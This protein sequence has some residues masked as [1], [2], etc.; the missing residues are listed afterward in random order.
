MKAQRPPVRDHLPGQ[1]LPARHHRR[2]A[3]A[4]VPPG[5]GARGGPRTSRW[6]TS[7]R[8]LELFAREMFGPRVA[9]A[10]PAVV[11]PVHRAVG[12]GRTCCCFKCGGDGC[13]FCKQSGW[14]EIL[15][16][17]MVHP[18]VLRNVGYDPE[19]VTG[20][21]FGMGV[22]RVAMLKYE[23]DDIRL[24]FEND[25]RFLAAVRR[26]APGD[27]DLVPLAPGVRRDGP[28][29]PRESPTASSMRASRWRR[30]PRSSRGS[31]GV[32]VGEIEAIERGA[33]RDRAPGHQQPPLRV[34]LP[35]RT[36]LRGLRRAQRARRACARRSRPPGATLPGGREIEAAKIRG[37]VSEGMLCSEKELGLGAG[38]RRHPR[39]CPPTRR[40]APISRPTSASTTRSSRSRSR[41][42]RPDALSVVGV[43]RE[44]AALTG[45]PLP[46]PAGRGARKPSRTRRRSP[47]STIDA[48]DLCPRF[49]ARGSSPGSP[50]ARRRPGSP[51]G[52]ARSGL[53]PINNLVDVTNYVLWELGQPLHAFDCDT[54]GRATRSW[55]GARG[56]ASGSRRSTA[57]ARALG[58][59]MAMVCDPDARASA[60][61]ASWA[62]PTAR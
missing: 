3:L 51:S 2:D 33:R 4:D 23:I 56:R 47:R 39:C 57:R 38:R 24:F 32:V 8:T 19:E 61:A 18:N 5:R 12:R 22:E 29:R 20:W 10:L 53:R 28:R 42:N 21:A 31:R 11:L 40:S 54:R 45:A 44:V 6:R 52:C 41:P 55:C 16:S 25:L 34:A 14:L 36:L 27:E 50:S 62:A 58:P 37:V 1:G 60:S 59:D 48:P 30:S 26:P 13:R 7:R 49:C 17:G 46:L 15:G 9:D 35:D 43:A